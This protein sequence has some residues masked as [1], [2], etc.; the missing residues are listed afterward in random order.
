[1]R[2]YNTLRLVSILSLLVTLVPKINSSTYI[3]HAEKYNRTLT[4]EAARAPL[5]TVA[6]SFSPTPS[7]TQ[8]LIPTA[9]PTF[10]PTL[11]PT[12]T[13]TPVPNYICEKTANDFIIYQYSGNIENKVIPLEELQFPIE[14][15]YV[16]GWIR[17]YFESHPAMD[18]VFSV[19]FNYGVPILPPSELATLV[20]TAE[21]VSIPLSNNINM[22][23]TIEFYHIFLE[24]ED[25]VKPYIFAYSHLKTAS[26]YQAMEEAKLNN[27]HTTI[28]GEIGHTGWTDGWHLHVNIIDLNML[29]ELTKTNSPKDA[30]DALLN[31]KDKSLLPAYQDPQKFYSFVKLYNFIPEEKYKEIQSKG[32]PGKLPTRFPEIT[33][34]GC[35][36]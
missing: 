18:I 10:M 17:G 35:H 25:G 11:T 16:P 2:L 22:S 13:P 4:H 6:P 20:A 26:M 3:N 27:G 21:K 33:I 8:T 15:K 30:I 5:Q 31:A 36:N 1:M 23:G 29:Y 32:T 7:A 14:K 34:V 28:A 9:T 24:T 19:G 12:F